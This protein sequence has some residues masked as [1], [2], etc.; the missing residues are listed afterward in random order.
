MNNPIEIA[1]RGIP[2]SGALERYIGDEAR[3]LH[4]ICDRIRSCQ[5]IAEAQQREKE[6]GARLAVRLEIMLPGTEVVVNREHGSDIYAAVH[7]AFAAAGRQLREHMRRRDMET[8]SRNGT[9][10]SRK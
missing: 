2:A 3:R 4:G 8:R 5:L 6:Q 10:K 9:P 1:L 7:D